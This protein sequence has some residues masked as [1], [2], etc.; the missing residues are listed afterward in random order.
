MRIALVDGA[1]EA[2]SSVEEGEKDA[3]PSYKDAMSRI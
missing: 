3:Y 1:D 2:I